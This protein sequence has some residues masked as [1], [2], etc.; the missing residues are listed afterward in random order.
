VRTFVASM[1]DNGNTSA[2]SMLAGATILFVIF[3]RSTA[4]RA[5][6]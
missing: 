4:P 3:P 1:A 2:A 5:R 6:E